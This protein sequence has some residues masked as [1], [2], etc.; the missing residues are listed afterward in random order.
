MLEKECIRMFLL[1]ATT[2]EENILHNL[3]QDY[4]LLF[5]KDFILVFRPYLK[6][7]VL[8]LVHH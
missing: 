6:D 1:T 8:V 7:L 3:Q 2:F 4:F 5:M